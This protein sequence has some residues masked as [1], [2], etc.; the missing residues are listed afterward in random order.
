M[1]I[2]AL[3]SPFDISITTAVDGVEAIE[4]AAKSDFDLILMDAQMPN[5]DGMTA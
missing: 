5:M 2:C 1:G 4:H 3:F